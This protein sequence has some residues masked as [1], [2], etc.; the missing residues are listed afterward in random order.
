MANLT[1]ALAANPRA[2]S[3]AEIDEVSGGFFPFIATGVAIGILYCM[4]DGTLD[5]KPGPKGDFPIGPK[6]VG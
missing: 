6:N 1:A 2:I 4:A 3:D 5:P